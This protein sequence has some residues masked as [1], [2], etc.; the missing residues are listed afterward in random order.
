VTAPDGT[1]AAVEVDVEAQPDA[2]GRA[3]LR[4][5]AVDPRGQGP[6]R[7]EFLERAS[8]RAAAA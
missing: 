3:L 4:A 2:A 6:W 5:P 7:L 1:V 8:A